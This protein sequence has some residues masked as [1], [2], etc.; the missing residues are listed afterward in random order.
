ME[1]TLRFKLGDLDARY[2]NDHKKYLYEASG[3][4]K[5]KEDFFLIEYFDL[6]EVGNSAATDAADCCSSSAAATTVWLTLQNNGNIR[7]GVVLEG[8]GVGTD[9]AGGL[10]Q[11]AERERGRVVKT[12]IA[13]V[14]VVKG[15][16]DK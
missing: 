8:M 9:S 10:L 11:M 16:R 1:L 3:R 6:E 4:L 13:V 2:N 14:V 15:G 5:E 7:V 12:P